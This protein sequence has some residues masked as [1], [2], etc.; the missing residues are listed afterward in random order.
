MRGLRPVLDFL[1]LIAVVLF[2]FVLLTL[3]KALGRK[4]EEQNAGE[5]ESRVKGSRSSLGG[6]GREVATF[7]KVF[8]A[9]GLTFKAKK[10]HYSKFDTFISTK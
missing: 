6:K 2:H 8:A 7:L 5:P 4:G 1:E 10:M 3:T 9:P